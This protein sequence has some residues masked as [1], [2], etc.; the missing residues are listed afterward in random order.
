MSSSD[1][2]P[3]NRSRNSWDFARSSA[4]DR[5]S[6]SGS[7]V[8][9]SRTTSSSFLT[10]RPSPMERT[11][12]ST[13]GIPSADDR[14]RRSILPAGNDFAGFSHLRDHR[15]RESSAG[16]VVLRVAERREQVETQRDQD[17]HDP[18]P[19]VDQRAVPGPVD[20]EPAH[21]RPHG[22]RGPRQNPGDAD[23]PAQEVLRDD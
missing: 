12:S 22:L 6:S 14:F 16:Q 19:E 20:E 8:L 18:D 3:S 7:N 13:T 21:E 10:L 23:D 4:S 15:L 11:L 17:Q 2:P 9:T 1:S 5:S